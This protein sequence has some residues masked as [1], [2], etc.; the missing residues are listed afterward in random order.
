MSTAITSSLAD[1]IEF[2]EVARYERREHPQA[3]YWYLMGQKELRF[4]DLP[5]VTRARKHFRSAVAADPSFAQAYSGSA[6]ATQR[7]WLVLGRGDHRVA[8]GG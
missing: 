2:A 4:M 7:Q 6:R 3:Y 8:R 5:S 1:A